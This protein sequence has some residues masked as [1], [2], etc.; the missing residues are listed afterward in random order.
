M[1][2]IWLGFGAWDGES[3]N[4]FI[5]IL[6]YLKPKKPQP[7]I[8]KFEHD[9]LDVGVTRA[10]AWGVLSMLPVYHEEEVYVR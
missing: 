6:Q 8:N 5:F 2:Y 9:L 7:G 4:C 10:I 3:Y 1:F